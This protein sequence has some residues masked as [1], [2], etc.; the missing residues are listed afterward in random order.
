M[1]VVEAVWAL[2]REDVGRDKRDVTK[3]NRSKLVIL[4]DRK[5]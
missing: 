4:A 1:P 5:R 2:A 3:R